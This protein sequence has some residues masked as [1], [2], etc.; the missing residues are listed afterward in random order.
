MLTASRHGSKRGR[1]GVDLMGSWR[2][3]ADNGSCP[4]SAADQGLQQGCAHAGGARD[5]EKKGSTCS[6]PRSSGASSWDETVTAERIGSYGRSGT[7][8]LWRLGFRVFD[9]G[10]EAGCGGALII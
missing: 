2:G 10:V 8:E 1:R 6:L 9:E 5:W 4:R 7:L 3:L